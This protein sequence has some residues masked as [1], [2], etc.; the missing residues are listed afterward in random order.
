MTWNNDTY[1]ESWNHVSSVSLFYSISSA[2]E[3]LSEMQITGIAEHYLIN[4]FK[5]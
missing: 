5:V 2:Y 4:D 1:C 3:G